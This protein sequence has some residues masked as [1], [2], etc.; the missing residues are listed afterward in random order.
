MTSILEVGCP[1]PG[2]RID[3]SKTRRGTHAHAARL[4]KN[5]CTAVIV[6]RPCCARMGRMRTVPCNASASFKNHWTPS[7]EAGDCLAVLTRSGLPSR[8]EL[9]NTLRKGLLAQDLPQWHHVIAT[10][11]VDCTYLPPRRKE[12]DSA[13][14]GPLRTTVVPAHSFK[15]MQNSALA[16]RIQRMG[17]H[18]AVRIGCPFALHIYDMLAAVA[19]TSWVMIVD[20]DARMLRDDHL[21]NLLSYLLPASEDTVFLQPTYLGPE[22]GTVYYHKRLWP[23]RLAKRVHDT[24]TAHWRVDT[25][26][27]VFHKRMVKHIKLSGGCGEDKEMLRQLLAAGCKLRV[28][29]NAHEVPA[30]VWANYLGPGSTPGQKGPWA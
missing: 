16:P 5:A 19:N 20:D 18:S 17:N 28:L 22:N 26:N 21:R 14:G 29:S 6:T 13:C 30:G 1:R 24:S 8:S 15:H 11:H 12:N 9:F 3:H 10:E 25:A 7:C 23:L 4:H 27:L 2:A